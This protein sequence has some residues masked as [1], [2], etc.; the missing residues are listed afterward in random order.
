MSIYLQKKQR[1]QIAAV[2][3]DAARS[4]ADKKVPGPSKFRSATALGMRKLKADGM[5]E[6]LAEKFSEH[7]DPKATT[8]VV[9]GRLSKPEKELV[10]GLSDVAGAGVGVLA[11]KIEHDTGCQCNKEI[12]SLIRALLQMGIEV[13]AQELS[14]APPVGRRRRRRR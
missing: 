14:S 9:D 7:V 1:D 13:A 12:L 8:G 10:D 4:V 6:K 5:P 3:R 11:D 2:A